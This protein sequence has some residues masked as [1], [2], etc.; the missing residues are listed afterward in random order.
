MLSFE[1]MMTPVWDTDTVYGESLTMVT[2]KDGN[3][4]APLLYDPAEVISV[5]DSAYEKCY[6]RGTDWEIEGN[7]FRMLRGSAMPHFS[8][9]E[10]F[11]KEK[12]KDGCFATPNGYIRFAEGSFFHTH[13]ISVTYKSKRGLWQGAKPEF[14]GKLLPKTLGKLKSGDKLKLVLF[15]D[16]ISWG[17]NA[18]QRANA[19]PYQ[20]PYAELLYEALSLRYPGGIHF[21]NNAIGGKDTVWGLKYL[22]PLVTEHKPDTVILAFGMNDGGKSPQEFCRNIEKMITDIRAENADTEFILIAT[23]TPNPVLT[24]PRAR[25][26]AN[27]PLFGAELKKLAS[28]VSGVA[29]ADITG[30]QKELHSHKRFIDTTGNN[31]NHPNDFFH[32]LYAQYLFGML[33][34]K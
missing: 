2:D 24:D 18:S 33:N 27:Q 12:M 28:A 30:M 3:S 8:E 31:V 13:Q 17:A 22:K 15:G 14:A 7:I 21:I 10:L 32:R 6:C 16:S 1:Q 23:S 4:A 25:F 20:K 19:E 9:D 34:E 11:S 26:Y 29:V 5:Y